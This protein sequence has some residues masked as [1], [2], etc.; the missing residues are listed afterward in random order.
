MKGKKVKKRTLKEKGIKEK[1]TK[2]IKERQR[3]D[4]N[5]GMTKDKGMTKTKE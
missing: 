2:V 4:K 3:N 1:R 5:K